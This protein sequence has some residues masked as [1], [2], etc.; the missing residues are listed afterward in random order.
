M[1]DIFLLR[2][3]ECQPL[4]QEQMADIKSQFHPANMANVNITP[5]IVHSPNERIIGEWQEEV[6]G[7]LKKKP[8][9]E[10][11]IRFDTLNEIDITSLNTD[12]SRCFIKDISVYYK[13]RYMASQYYTK[14]DDRFNCYLDNN[15]GIKILFEGSSNISNNLNNGYIC[16]MYVKTTDEWEVVE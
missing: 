2:R 14:S 15:D 6:D 10:K 4:T 13:S 5:Y 3:D 12:I 8:L 1:N 7:V 11:R 9:Y 16:V